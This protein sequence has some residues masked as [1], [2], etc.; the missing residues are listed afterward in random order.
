MWLGTLTTL[1]AILVSLLS[2]TEHAWYIPKSM[3]KSCGAHSRVHVA[4]DRVRRLVR[5]LHDIAGTPANQAKPIPLNRFSNPLVRGR[6][7][8]DTNIRLGN[9]RRGTM[10]ALAY[11]AF[12]ARR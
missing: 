2:F 11:L 12:A 4:I 1:L 8:R 10:I 6:R 9:D 5:L 7:T 3:M